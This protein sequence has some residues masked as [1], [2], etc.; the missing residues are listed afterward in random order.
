MNSLKT[1]EAIVATNKALLLV[2]LDGDKIEPGCLHYLSALHN[3]P[4]KFIDSEFIVRPCPLDLG[5]PWG[6]LMMFVGI[7]FFVLCFI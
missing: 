4:V 2:T 6:I 1:W 5:L 3:F 7:D